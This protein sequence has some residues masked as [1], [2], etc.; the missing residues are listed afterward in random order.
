MKNKYQFAAVALAAALVLPLLHAAG[1]EAAPIP[2][3]IGWR[4]NMLTVYSPRIP[5]GKL[6][7]WYLEAF[8]RRRSTNRKWEKTVIPFK[9]R[10]L[11]AAPDGRRIRLTSIVKPGVVVTHDISVQNGAVDFRLTLT[12]PTSH[13]VDI[14]W[15]QPCIRVKSFTGLGQAEYIRKCFLFTKDGLVTLD[16]THRTVEARYHG[17][18][19]YV[20][21]GIDRRDV[22]PRPLSPDVPVNG[23]IGCYS[24]DNKLLLAMAWDHVQELF[25]GVIVCIHSDFHIGGLKAAETK[26]LH[27]RLY[28]M[29]NNPG[30]LLTR[31]HR[32]FGK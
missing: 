25:Q 10:L 32:D 1:P 8:C 19:V 7:I 17:G 14:E 26:K 29:E 9:T 23:L 31:Y 12:N 27:G 5:T 6:Q 24:K 13:D 3:R 4:D 21:A 20:P 11:S 15:A 2:L 18:Q 22:N 30:K 16:K 28:I